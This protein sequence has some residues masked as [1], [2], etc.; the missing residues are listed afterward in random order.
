MERQGKVLVGVFVW[1]TFRCEVSWG[2]L[3]QN[4]SQNTMTRESRGCELCHEYC[5]YDETL[6]EE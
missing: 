4:K 2:F 3:H 5:V 6:Y 1:T